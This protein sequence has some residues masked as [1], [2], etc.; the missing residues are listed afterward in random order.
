MS[1]CQVILGCSL[2]VVLLGANLLSAQTGSAMLYANGNV[3]VNGLAAGNSTAVFSGD[4][5]E[6]PAASAGSINL[7]GSSVVV[8]PNSAIQYS[9]GSVDVIQGGARVSTSKGMSATAGPVVVSPIDA[10]AKFDVVKTSDKVVVISREG[11]LN[12]KDGDRTIAVASG[13]STEL[14]LLASAGQAAAQ[15][16]ASSASSANFLSSDRLVQHPFYGVLNGVENNPP[17]LPICAN[18]TTCLRPSVSQIHPCCCPPVVL[19]H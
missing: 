6:V 15:N 17:S 2:L 13:S 16:S 9:S 7:V 5:V 4:K 19:C 14:P 12:V 3:T 10:S 1:R 11:G 18:I 8:N